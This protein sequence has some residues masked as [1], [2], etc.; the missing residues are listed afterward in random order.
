MTPRRLSRAERKQETRA[1]LLASAQR[2]F[3]RRGFHA[4]SV[5]E[6]AEEAGF[7]KGAVYSN[8]SGK[9]DLFLAMIDARFQRR[10]ADVRAAV[11]GPGAPG[12]QARRSGEGFVRALADDP[13]WPPLFAEFWAYALRHPPVRR[14]FAARVRALR[15]GVADILAVQADQAG[16]RLPVPAEALAAMTFAMATGIAMERQLDPEAV[17]HDLFGTMLELLFAGVRVQAAPGEPAVAR[18]AG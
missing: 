1:R 14:R 2:V 9:E 15:R 18:A 4:A 17:P 6:V 7:S 16:V 12:E 11:A 10:L 5:E 3:A 8:F 13:E